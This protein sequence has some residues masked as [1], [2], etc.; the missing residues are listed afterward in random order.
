MATWYKPIISVWEGETRDSKLETSLVY[1]VRLIKNSNVRESAFIVRTSSEDPFFLDL[2]LAHCYEACAADWQSISN[3]PHIG[4]QQD[5][6]KKSQLQG[7][8]SLVAFALWLREKTKPNTA[9]L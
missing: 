6:I 7:S 3:K 4:R 9:I 1:T 8:A 5:S 2:V